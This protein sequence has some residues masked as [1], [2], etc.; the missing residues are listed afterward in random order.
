MEERAAFNKHHFGA[1]FSPFDFKYGEALGIVVGTLFII[2]GLL[3]VRG[4]VQLKG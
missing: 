4:V 2:F 1:K 3:L